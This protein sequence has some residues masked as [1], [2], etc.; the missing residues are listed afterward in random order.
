MSVVR[1]VQGEAVVVRSVAELALLRAG[2]LPIRSR[3]LRLELP[4]LAPGEADQ[5]AHRI[6]TL[7]REC[8]CEVGSWFAYPVV[9]AVLAWGVFDPPGRGLPLLQ[10]LGLSLGAV[11]LA[12]VIGKGIGVTRA[13]RRL[14]R[15]IDL[16][17]ARIGVSG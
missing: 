9:A 1:P 17:Q 2:R 8:G 6:L 4:G 14:R 3:G 5:I 15:E 11:L 10:R 7:K 12:A 13:L 16:L